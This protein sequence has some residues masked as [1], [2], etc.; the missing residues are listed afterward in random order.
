MDVGALTILFAE[1]TGVVSFVHVGHNTTCGVEG[2]EELVVG[3][4]FPCVVL[5]T[6]SDS[7]DVLEG[8]A[9]EDIRCAHEQRLLS[10]RNNA[11]HVAH[12]VD[13]II[14]KEFRVP[15]LF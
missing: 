12:E 14:L 11:V 2:V 5:Q 7:M 6:N 4:V 1:H 15:V 3:R 13:L 9:N 10:D 8:V